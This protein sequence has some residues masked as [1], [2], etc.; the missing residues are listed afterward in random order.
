MPAY[1]IRL[2]LVGS[3]MFIRD[4]LIISGAKTYQQ[5]TD[6][7]DFINTVFKKNYSEVKREIPAFLLEEEK[8]KTKTKT[9]TVQQTKGEEERSKQSGKLQPPKNAEIRWITP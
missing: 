9:K 7:Y 2:S 4:R 5:I 1:S 3:E 6:A 8:T